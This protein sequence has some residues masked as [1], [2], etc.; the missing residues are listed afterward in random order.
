MKEITVKNILE[1]TDGE[2]IIGN[3]EQTCKVFSKD[4]RIINPGDVYIG[5]KGEAF[6]G[7]NFWKEACKKG[8]SCVIVENIDFTKEN[9]G[10]YKGR[11]IIKVKDTLEALYNIAR[12]K[13][14]SYNIPVIAI[15]GSVG[16]TSTKDIIAN[17][18]S[19]NLK[20]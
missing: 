16:K 10:E 2:L 3:Q 5:I 14:E 7:S 13:R 18:V 15:T 11:I 6:D 4:T 9:L 12:F 17:V 8:A 20:H 1:V 19:Q